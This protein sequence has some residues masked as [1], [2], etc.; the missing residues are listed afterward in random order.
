M[1]PKEQREWLAQQMRGLANRMAVN[2]HQ[3][4][5]DIERQYQ[6]ECSVELRHWW[7]QLEQARTV[8]KQTPPKA[9]QR[10]RIEREIEEVIEEAMRG[11]AVE[12]VEDASSTP[13][14]DWRELVGQR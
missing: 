5:R 2:C 1:T 11:E 14:P 4:M 10:S 9:D 8:L 7:A 12:A 13:K 6:W 3:A